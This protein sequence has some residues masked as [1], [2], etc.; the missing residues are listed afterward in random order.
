MFRT[1]YP[2][3]IGR[4]VSTKNLSNPESQSIIMSRPKPTTGFEP[5]RQHN[6]LP[7]ATKYRLVSDFGLLERPV[8]QKIQNGNGDLAGLRGLQKDIAT[9]RHFLGRMYISCH[10]CILSEEDITSTDQSLA[11]SWP[12]PALL[13]L[14]VLGY[15]FSELLVSMTHPCIDEFLPML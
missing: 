7:D 12:E 14:S 4:F 3:H 8:A 9:Y 2:I 6:N 1:H 10:N 11:G 5:D 13:C 15:L